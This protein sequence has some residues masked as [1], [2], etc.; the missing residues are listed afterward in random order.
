MKFT[1]YNRTIDIEM[2]FSEDDTDFSDGL[3][4]GFTY[5]EDI[6]CWI[7]DSVP[8]LIDW[9]KAWE[10]YEANDPLW[11]PDSDESLYGKRYVVIKEIENAIEE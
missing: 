8:S 2:R 9:L 7:V 4:E 3:M 1:D 5:D 6:D 10:R 11:T